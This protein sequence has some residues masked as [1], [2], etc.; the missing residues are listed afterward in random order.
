MCHAAGADTIT[1]KPGKISAAKKI[2]AGEDPPAEF[3]MPE[4]FKNTR[5]G[6]IGKHG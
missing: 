2:S 1:N 4:V 5:L 3:F 6:E